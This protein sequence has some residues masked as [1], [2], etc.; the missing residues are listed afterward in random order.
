MMKNQSY[1]IPGV[2][3]LTRIGPGK[4]I[5]EFQVFGER[6][7]GTNY[8]GYVFAKNTYLKQTR[9]YGWKHGIP[10]YPVFPKRCLFVVVVREPISW[11]KSFFNAPFEADEKLV[12]DDFSRFIRS[13]WVGRYRPIRSSWSRWGYDLDLGVG[14]G[15]ELQLDR[16]PLT[17]ERFSN[18]LELRSLKLTAMVGL[19]F[20]NVNAVVVRHEEFLSDTQQSLAGICDCFGVAKKPKYT[21]VKGRVGP[22]GDKLKPPVKFEIS[23]ADREFIINQLDLETEKFC[24]YLVDE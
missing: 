12:M 11:I 16:H 10:C 22:R 2:V 6:R 1:D 23:N 17:G 8:A 13:E 14:R 4:K 20:R 21:P 15:Q 24:G 9:R 3:A 7:S 19:L 5:S 18:P